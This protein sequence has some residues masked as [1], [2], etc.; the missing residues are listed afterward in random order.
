MGF[1]V[2]FTGYIHKYEAYRIPKGTVVKKAADEDVVLSEEEENRKRLDQLNAEASEAVNGMN[3]AYQ[4]FSDV[5]VDNIVETTPVNIDFSSLK[6]MNL[7]SGITGRF[8]DL[9]V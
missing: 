4:Q 9:S 3:S 6:T 7:G 2:D 5:Q 1:S 8:I